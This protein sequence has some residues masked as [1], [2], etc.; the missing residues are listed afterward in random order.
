MGVEEAGWET[1]ETADAL[2]ILDVAE[3]VIVSQREIVWNLVHCQR[4]VH[5][6]Y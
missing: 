5:K 1:V 4:G 3:D 2:F 6:I